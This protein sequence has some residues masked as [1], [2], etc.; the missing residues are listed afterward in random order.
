MRCRCF[1]HQPSKC[2]ADTTSGGHAGV[3]EGVDLVVADQQVAAAGPLLE[4]GEF[5]AQPGVVAEEVVAGL[6]VALDERVPDEQ[7]PGQLADRPGRTR[8]GGGPPAAG[9]RASPARRPSPRR[10]WHP[11]A[12]RCRCAAPAR[13]RRARPPPVR[14]ARRSARTAC[15][16]RPGRRR[17]SSAAAAWSAPSRA[18]ARTWSCARP[19]YS[20]VVTLAQA[21]VRQQPGEQRRVHPGRVGRLGSSLSRMP[22]SRAMLRSWP[23]RSCHSRMRR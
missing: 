18:R 4:L 23:V 12:A 21:D 11:S 7:F 17:R 9:R 5:L 10:A 16:S 6:P 14:C 13:P 19:A 15:W 8:C 22:R 3:V 20:R 2:R 1:F